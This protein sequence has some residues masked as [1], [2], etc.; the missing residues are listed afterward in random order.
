MAIGAPSP[1]ANRDWSHGSPGEPRI[2]RVLHGAST[3]FV[4][5][6]RDPRR[7]AA[8]LGAMPGLRIWQALWNTASAVAASL[9]VSRWLAGCP[10]GD[11]GLR[12]AAYACLPGGWGEADG[13]DRA[14][15]CG[16]DCLRDGGNIAEH[17]SSADLLGVL[18]RLGS[19]AV[20]P[21]ASG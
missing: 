7:C 12:F 5:A 20:L 21:P 4:L 14:A 1:P 19:I 17:L 16:L 8:S 3:S 18:H 13:W 9:T 2:R 10:V 11:Y 6:L 15:T